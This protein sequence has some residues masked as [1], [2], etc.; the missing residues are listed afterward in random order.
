MRVISWNLR[1]AR[2]AGAAWRMLT[3]L[4]PDIALL[5]EVSGIPKNV[6]ES[7][8]IK[9]QTA[10][11]KTGKPQQFGTAIL[12]KGTITDGLPLS[13]EFDWVNRELKHFAGNLVSAVV[14]P[15][16]GPMVNVVS[17]YSPAWPI[18][19]SR[20]HGVDVTAVKLK[21]N[22]RLWVTDILW[23]AL[24]NA[25]VTTVPWIVGGDFNSSET[26][27]STFGCG[28]RETLDR[29]EAL[30]FTECLRKCSGRLTP[31]FRHS[32]GGVIHQMDHLFVTAPLS[33]AMD[34][35]ATGDASVVFGESV[36]DHLPVI[37]D[38]KGSLSLS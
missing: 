11:G 20:Y 10:M 34:N 24:K 9:L 31:T 3:G 37:G 21:Q 18:N 25:T 4:S 15:T 38:F 28:N 23:S 1:R 2:E 29:M 19:A 5:Q 22:P 30:G 13:S 16:G 27:D 8:D 26:F 33:S 14:Q 35:C 12:V 6:R 17:V 32:S 36:S 7:F